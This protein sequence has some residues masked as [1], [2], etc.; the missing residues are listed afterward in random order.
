MWNKLL[1]ILNV[2]RGRP[3]MYRLTLEPIVLRGEAENAHACLVEN[4]YINDDGRRAG[5]DM[6]P[7]GDLVEK[8]SLPDGAITFPLRGE[9][10]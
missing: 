9:E 7:V 8:F 3:V 10:S 2:L 6:K 4:K 5:V 1:V